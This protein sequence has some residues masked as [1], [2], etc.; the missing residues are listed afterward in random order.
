MPRNSTGSILCFPNNIRRENQHMQAAKKYRM[1]PCC[2]KTKHV[3]SCRIWDGYPL[4]LPMPWVHPFLAA[5]NAW[6]FKAC[7]SSW[8]LMWPSP[9]VSKIW[10][11]AL[12]VR[13]SYFKGEVKFLQWVLLSIVPSNAQNKMSTGTLA[14]LLPLPSKKVPR[15]GET[16]EPAQKASRICVVLVHSVVLQ[17]V[18]KT[19]NKL[20][21]A[22]MPRHKAGRISAVMFAVL[23][24]P[25]G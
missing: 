6:D 20:M 9:F 17:A 18:Q 15:T 11:T 16:K 22:V 7:W 4:A 23:G 21:W 25:L 2:L 8:R 19:D 12:S 3:C 1:K 13:R 14:F 10:K 5:L 24:V